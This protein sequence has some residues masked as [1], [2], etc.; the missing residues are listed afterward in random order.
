MKRQWTMAVAVM[1]AAVAFSAADAQA[2]VRISAAGGPSFPTG[3]NHLDM[4]F[5]VQLAGELGVPMLP[6]GFRVDGMFNRFSE[7]HGNYDVLSGTANAIF[8]IPM[9]GLTPYIIGGVGVYSAEDHA[10]D[11]ERETNLGVNIGAGARLP[12]PG[13]GVF[14]EARYHAPFGDHALRFVPVSFGIRF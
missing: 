9:V 4:G 7:D 8:N 11:E 6:F 14:V 2:Q 1:A 5:H 12:L 13:L 10:H 3:E